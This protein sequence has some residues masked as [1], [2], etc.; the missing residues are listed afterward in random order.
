MAIAENAQTGVVLQDRVFYSV[1]A[2]E[3]LGFADALMSDI[4][5]LTI[6]GSYAVGALTRSHSDNSRVIWT[7]VSECD[8]HDVCHLLNDVPLYMEIQDALLD[9]EIDIR[10]LSE[11]CAK[12]ATL[13]KEQ[14]MSMRAVLEYTATPFEHWSAI[15]PSAVFIPSCP[16]FILKQSAR[17]A[18]G[19][20][21]FFTLIKTNP[22]N[23]HRQRHIGSVSLAVARRPSHVLMQD[24]LYLIVADTPFEKSRSTL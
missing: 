10:L 16:E 3:F 22:E 4:G 8:V 20:D 24:V 7:P 5:G 14:F 1:T 13:S 23:M 2:G 12:T 6:T 21:D 18:I 19:P 17:V 11:L 15:Y 9:D